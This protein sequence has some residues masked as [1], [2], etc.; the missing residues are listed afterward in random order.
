VNTSPLLEVSGIERSFG[1]VR[2]L[3]GMDL[4]VAQGECSALIGPNGSG[5]STLVNVVTR[6]VDAEAG[7]VRLAGS[8]IT[9][10]RKHRVASQGVARTFQHVRLIP[11]LTLRE[12]AAAGAI[13]RGLRAFGSEL[14]GFV[15]GRIKRADHAAVEAALD[16]MEV[17]SRLRDRAPREVPFAVQRHTE[18][19]RAMASSP[20]LV[21]LDEPAAGM[22]PAEVKVLLRLVGAINEAGVAIVVIEHNMDF[23]MQAARTIT[24]INRGARIAHGPAEEVRRDPAVIEAYLGTRR[25]NGEGAGDE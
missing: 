24:V 21:L 15:N 17:P 16:L 25:A 9:R 14:R 7:S 20:R 23:V 19:A 13:H 11:E 8:D 10:I 3:R 6:M 18:M 2:A 22:N 1:G 12:N 5:K 4:S